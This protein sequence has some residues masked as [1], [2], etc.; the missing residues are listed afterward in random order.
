MMPFFLK[1]FKY[2]LQIKNK[3]RLIKLSPVMGLDPA[4]QYHH[5]HDQG[6]AAN[7]AA[8]FRPGSLKTMTIITELL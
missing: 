1:Y 7:A 5:N 8:E 3:V 6:Q 2:S 4:P